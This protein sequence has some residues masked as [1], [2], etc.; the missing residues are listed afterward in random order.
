MILK[1]EYTY[2]HLGE[3]QVVIQRMKE[4]SPDLLRI[5]CRS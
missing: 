2:R 3:D 5:S 1:I 4:C